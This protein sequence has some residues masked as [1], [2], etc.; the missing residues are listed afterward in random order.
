MQRACWHSKCILFKVLGFEE[1]AMLNVLF[2]AHATQVHFFHNSCNQSCNFKNQVQAIATRLS[3]HKGFLFIKNKM[4][5][6]VCIQCIHVTAS[7]IAHWLLHVDLV[8][9]F[10]ATLAGFFAT[11]ATAGFLACLCPLAFGFSPF[12]SWMAWL[13]CAVV[14]SVISSSQVS[15][16]FL[17]FLSNLYEG[18][19][20]TALAHK[21]LPYSTRCLGI[22]AAFQ[23]GFHIQG[24]NP[25]WWRPG[26]S[27]QAC[28]KIC[29]AEH[30]RVQ[31]CMKVKVAL[32][33]SWAFHVWTCSLCTALI[34]MVAL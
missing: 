21:E 33:F 2:Q 15:S 25:L 5:T 20:K 18:I 11:F 8:A 1:L 4:K 31:Q 9:G 13:P 10:F 7:K 24:T 34:G 17:F 23:L 28:N 6:K 12:L 27:L 3:V 26:S 29:K 16:T 14:L 22:H 30:V 19:Y 32:P